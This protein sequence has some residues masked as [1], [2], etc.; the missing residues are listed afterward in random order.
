ME[1]YIQWLMKKDT[2]PITVKYYVSAVLQFQRWHMN[3]TG[4]KSFAPSGV[5]MLEMQQ[6]RDHMLNEATYTK[7]KESTPKRYSAASVKAYLQALKSFFDYLETTGAVQRNPVSKVMISGLL[8]DNVRI[9]R[10]LDIQEKGRLIQYLDDPKLEQKNV[11]K[12]ARN[13]AIF[14]LGLYAGLRNREITTLRKT[15]LHF[16]E[17]LIIVR[18]N[19]GEQPRTVEMS[20]TLAKVLQDWIQVRGDSPDATLILTTRNEAISDKGMWRLFNT[21]A[22]KVEIPDLSPQVLRHTFARQLVE[23]GRPLPLV[24]EILGIHNL[25]DILVYRMI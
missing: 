23:E 14:Y 20:A 9:P 25:K 7:S 12:Y 5:T 4:S 2:Q 3:E 24:A 8:E 1:S 11:W 16:Q 13:R 15:D 17:E 6:W 19:T 21:I 18:N 10:W 22:L